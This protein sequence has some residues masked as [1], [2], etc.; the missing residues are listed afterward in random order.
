MPLFTIRTDVR[1]PTLT[2]WLSGEFDLASEPE[3]RQA[4]TLPEGSGAV[5]IRLDASDVTFVECI[6]LGLIERARLRL[7]RDGGMLSI[8]SPAE[9]FARTAKLA[10]YPGLAA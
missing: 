3:L 2:I 1:A 4:L 6:S 9:I 7:D 10:D 8:I 5:D